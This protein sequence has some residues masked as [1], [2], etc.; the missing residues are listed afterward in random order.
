MVGTFCSSPKRM[1]NLGRSRCKASR[2]C[3]ERAFSSL[4]SSF[5]SIAPRTRN[6]NCDHVE[7]FCSFDVLPVMSGRLT[8]GAP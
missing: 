6:P 1:A 5:F 2:R 8:S 7:R 4:Y 3:S